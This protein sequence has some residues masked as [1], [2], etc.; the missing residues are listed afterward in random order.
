MAFILY[1][2]VSSIVFLSTD[3]LSEMSF[4]PNNLLYTPASMRIALKSTHAC[5]ENSTSAV[6]TFFPEN[7]VIIPEF[8]QGW[9]TSVS[10]LTSSTNI[11]WESNEISNNIPDN[12]NELFWVWI[13]VPHTYTV[14]TK[15]YAPTVQTCYPSGQKMWTDITS[16]S[17]H[18]APYFTIRDPTS[19]ENGDSNYLHHYSRLDMLTISAAIISIITFVT[20]VYNEYKKYKN[21]PQELEKVKEKVIEKVKEKVKENVNE[22]VKEKEIEIHTIEV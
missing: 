20:T 16:P 11:K 21:A 9:T 19:Y 1:G 18:L 6:E 14:N 13:T 2:I 15:Y 17:E 12:V 8:K 4:Y 10:T 3:P 7:F 5:I 22:K